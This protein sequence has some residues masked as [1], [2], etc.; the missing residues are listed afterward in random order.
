MWRLFEPVKVFFGKDVLKEYGAS[1]KEL[2]KS[3]LIVT[4]SSSSKKNGS[5]S[6]VEEVLRDLS[7]SFELYDKVGENPSFD[8]LRDALSLYKGKKFDFVVGVG[9]GSPMDFAKALAILLANPHLKVPEIFDTDKYTKMLPVVAVPTTSGTGSEVTQYSV[10]TDDDGNKRGFGTDFTFPTLS[11]V[12]PKFTITMPEKVTM[13]T[14]IDALCHAVEG[15]V[16]KKSSP[17]VRLLAIEAIKLIKENIQIA[18]KEPQNWRARE[19][20]MY[21]SMLA[22]VVIAQAGTTIN[23]AF[24]YPVTIFKGIRH[25][26]ATGIFL[27]ETLKVMEKEN[28]DGVKEVASIFDGLE[29]LEQFLKEVGVFDI[30][31]EIT[32]TDIE[33]WSKRTS[34]ARHIAVTYGNW[35]FDTVKRIYEKIAAILR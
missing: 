30:K 34:K 18:M 33:K 6:D 12:D 7:I 4:G 35:D 14:G 9:G 1:I 16:S 8:M 22:G 25:G 19:N 28:P 2:G 10:I 17:Y 31:V 21:A 29:G 15:F 24:G 13:S 5:L 11:F 26:Q 27:V 20:M 23:H 32:P 3:A